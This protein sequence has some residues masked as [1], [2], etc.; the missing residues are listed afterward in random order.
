MGRSREGRGGEGGR[1]L[2]LTEHTHPVP[3][4]DVVHCSNEANPPKPFLL[5]AFASNPGG[6]LSHT[7]CP[8]FGAGT[9]VFFISL[10]PTSVTRS[11]L[12]F[13]LIWFW[14]KDLLCS[15]GSP[16]FTILLAPCHDYRYGSLCQ[17][18]R[19]Y[20]DVC[21]YLLNIW[22]EGKGGRE[23]EKRRRERE[24][25]GVEER[26]EEKRGNGRNVTPLFVRCPLIGLKWSL[27]T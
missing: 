26:E 27:G 19:T 2:T 11:V 10:A 17:A 5:V 15:T 9:N 12:L 6:S 21:T 4:L 25:R 20:S 7:N 24:R 3:S 16:E 23:K 14:D 13:Y 8:P 1:D 18:I 22:R